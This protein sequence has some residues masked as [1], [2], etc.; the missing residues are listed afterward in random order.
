MHTV[1]RTVG[2]T[3]SLGCINGKDFEDSVD[4]SARDDRG[5]LAVC[6]AHI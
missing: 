2:Q 5:K 6:M 4:I 1:S 3:I